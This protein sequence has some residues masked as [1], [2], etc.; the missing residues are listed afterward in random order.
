[1]NAGSRPKKRLL[2]QR[3]LE[4]IDRLCERAETLFHHT[5]YPTHLG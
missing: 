2:S 3:Q 5:G 1:M 4:S